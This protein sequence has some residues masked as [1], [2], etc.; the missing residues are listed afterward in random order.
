MENT[1]R[2]ALFVCAVRV[3]RWCVPLVCAVGMVSEGTGTSMHLIKGLISLTLKIAVTEPSPISS[4]AGLRQPTADS[5]AGRHHESK[6]R[7]V[8]KTLRQRI[9][10]GRGT[11]LM[12]FMPVASPSRDDVSSDPRCSSSLA[13]LNSPPE[14]EPLPHDPGNPRGQTR[15]VVLI[16]QLA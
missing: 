8:K 4:V 1:C 3:C 12:A 15:A 16:S 13:G 10:D 6:V 5:T 2:V 9:Q 7:R 14:L 11:R